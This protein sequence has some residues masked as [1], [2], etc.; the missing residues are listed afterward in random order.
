MP[1][2]LDPLDF[3]LAVQDDVGADPRLRVHAAVVAAQ[4]KHAKKGEDGKKGER[5]AAAVRAGKGRFAPS[6]PP[7]LMLVD[8]SAGKQ[9]ASG[10]GGVPA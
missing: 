1:P 2:G 5:Q 9:R 7:R 6:A 8:T 3:L 10:G 4:Y